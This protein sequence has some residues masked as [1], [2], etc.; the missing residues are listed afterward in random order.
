MLPTQ[1]NAVELPATQRAITQSSSGQLQ[2]SEAVPLPRL[3][4]GT[5]LIKTLAVSLQPADY[6][7]ARRFPSNGAVVGSD[8]A[9]I[10]MHIHPD[11]S[12]H[13]FLRPGDLICGVVHGS[14]TSSE[15]DDRNNG[16]FA[17]Y[18][19][20][21]VRLLLRI[22]TKANMS[23]AQAATLGTALVTNALAFWADPL[24]MRLIP[25][26]EAKA[27]TPFPVMVYGG[28]SSVGTMATQLL[29][30]SGL[31]PIVTCSPHNFE[32]VRSYG[33]D[34]VFDYA[35][36]SGIEG[37]ERVRK[38][39][40]GRLRH[41]LDCAVDED[42]VAC[43]YAALGRIGGRYISLESCQEELR[44]KTGRRTVS[45]RFV[46]GLESFGKEVQLEGD[47]WRPGSDKMFE[48][49]AQFFLMVQRLLD[50]GTL[51]PHP[52]ELID[53]GFDGIIQGLQRLQQGKISGKK[54]AVLIP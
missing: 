32:L 15:Q 10:I 44:L 3:L 43:C 7:M 14:N 33:A 17:Q 20:A 22:S 51:K 28:S 53:G 9:G 21:P 52:V 6:K 16:A 29:H 40:G 49:V 8:F 30:L 11:S 25:T 54:L 50:D 27:E 37:G 5:A 41:V 12:Q 34:L 26:V 2:I 31:K 35:R 42:S 24:A 18:L 1:S 4:P 36:P 47:Y 23:P 39:T 45:Y 48:S 38:E 19:R 46:M 13:K